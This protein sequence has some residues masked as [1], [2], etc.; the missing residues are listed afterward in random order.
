MAQGAVPRGM[1]GEV[2]AVLSRPAAMQVTLIVVW[3]RRGGQVPTVGRATATAG[4]STVSPVPSEQGV[5]V[6][7]TVAPS[8]NSPQ[9]SSPQA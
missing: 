8:P 6:P 7:L 5:P 9:L 4:S 1:A 3:G 2:M